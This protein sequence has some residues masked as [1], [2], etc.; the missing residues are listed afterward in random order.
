MPQTGTPTRRPKRPKT[1]QAPIVSPV[2]GEV[3]T[4]EEAAAYLRVSEQE[5]DALATRCVLPGR[6]IG[7]QWRFHRC[8]LVDWLCQSS[9]TERLMRHAG[10]AKDD[11]YRDEMLRM[12]YQKRGRPMTENEL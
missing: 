7:D 10:A 5:V 12:I 2:V 11:P 1:R 4:L 3:L 8:A 6:K 9:P